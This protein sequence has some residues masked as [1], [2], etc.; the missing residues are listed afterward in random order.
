MK[1]ERIDRINVLAK[2]AK[3]VGLTPDELTERDELRREY[4]KSIRENFKKTLDS[5]EVVDKKQ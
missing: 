2:K 5:I 1:Q 3:E 4:L